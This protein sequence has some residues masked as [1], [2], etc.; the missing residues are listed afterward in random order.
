[1]LPR[2]ARNTGDQL[3]SGYNRAKVKSCGYQE[4]ISGQGLTQNIYPVDFKLACF[5]FLSL[6]GKTPP[7]LFDDIHL[8]SEGP[9]H[10]L[11]SSTDRSCAVPCTHNTGALL[12]PGHVFGT[13]CQGP[14]CDED[15]TYDSF[16]RELKTYWF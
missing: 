12:L 1:M 6:S 14:L 13:A 7:Y 4:Y 3:V 8:V 5:V 11:R 15:I 2:L 9:R 16:R 10:Q